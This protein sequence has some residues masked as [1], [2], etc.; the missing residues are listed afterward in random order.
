MQQLAV[1]GDGARTEESERV[2]SFRI[3]SEVLAVAVGRVTEIVRP[4]QITEV[5][6]VPIFVK[7]VV[8]LRGRIIPVLSLRVRLGLEE[9]ETT[10]STRIVVVTVADES[11]GMIVDAVE[12]VVSIPNSAVTPPSP[13][14]VSVDADFVRGIARIGD[15]QLVVLLDVD[16]VTDRHAAAE[17]GRVSLG[18]VAGTPSLPAAPDGPVAP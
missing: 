8:N 16:R 12:Q 2:V 9:Q 4:R 18:P 13:V 7:G 11:V 17:P 10:E 1:I 14:F 3:G 6:Q 15:S 5:P